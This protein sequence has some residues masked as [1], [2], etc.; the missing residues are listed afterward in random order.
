MPKNFVREPSCDVFQKISG[1]KNLWIR[2][3]EYQEFPSNILCPTVP[4]N[5]VREPSCDVFQKISGS[6]NFMDKGV[7]VPR[8]SVEYFVSHSAEKIGR[9]TPLCCVSE[10][11]WRREGSWIRGGGGWSEDGSIKI[12]PRKC[13]VSQCRNIS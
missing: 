13:F 11:F 2:G 7:G 6:K 3:G 8:V 12:S 4:K 10:N 9:G 5:F 1:S